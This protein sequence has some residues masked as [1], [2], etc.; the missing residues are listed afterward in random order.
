MVDVGRS[1]LHHKL[2]LNENKIMLSL[3][4]FGHAEIRFVM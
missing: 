3:P 4:L 1:C 2:I